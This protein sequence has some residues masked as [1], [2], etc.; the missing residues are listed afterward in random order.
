MK[1]YLVYIQGLLIG[2][3]LGL[4]VVSMLDRVSSLNRVC[5]FVVAALVFNVV[6]RLLMHILY[7]STS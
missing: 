4:I 3:I 7:A 2:V 1:D 5:V 6:Y